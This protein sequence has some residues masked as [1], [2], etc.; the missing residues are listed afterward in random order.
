MKRQSLCLFMYKGKPWVESMWGDLHRWYYYQLWGVLIVAQTDD[1]LAFSSP[2]SVPSL[3]S[4]S[5]TSPPL[6]TLDHTCMHKVCARLC[7]EECI[8]KEGHR[9]FN[10]KCVGDCML[11]CLG[12]NEGTEPPA[13]A[14][15]FARCRKFIRNIFGYGIKFLY[16]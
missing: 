11:D 12:R 6:S 2:T 4:L 3:L 9:P 14:D 1:L 10:M 15:A 16:Q 13:Y 5:P 8:A 7:D